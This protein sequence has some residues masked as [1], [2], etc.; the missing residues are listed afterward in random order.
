MKDNSDIIHSSFWANLFKPSTQKH[1]HELVLSSFPAFITL[2]RKEI[3][4]I[5]NIIH[6]RHYIAGE[7]I[8]CQ[9]DPG[10]GLYILVDGEVEITYADEN[11][12]C[13]RFAS[14]SKGDFF[15]ELAL[16]DGEKRNA[17]A[18]AK[19]DVKLAVIFKPD[20]DEFIEKFPKIGI[21]IMQGLS[22]IVTTRLRKL[23]E[24]YLKIQ[25]KSLQME[26]KYGT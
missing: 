21:R 6:N 12:I 20:L 14:F 3:V 4:L 2:S 10:I 18:I 13:L 17:S 11:G 19:S 23:D 7:Y 25:S 16:V 26:G 5:S 1:D 8:F 24:D 22:R 15:G 9:G